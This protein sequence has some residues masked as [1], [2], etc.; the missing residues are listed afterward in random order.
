MKTKDLYLLLLLFLGFLLL[1]TDTALCIRIPITTKDSTNTQQP[2]KIAVSL[3]GAS[4]DPNL[5]LGV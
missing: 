4:G 3:L 5:C 2:L 1:I